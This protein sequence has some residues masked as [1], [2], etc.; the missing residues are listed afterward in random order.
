MRG[1]LQLKTLKL[2][3]GATGATASVGGQTVPVTFTGGAITFTS[4]LTIPQGSTLT[5]TLTSAHSTFEVQP[6][7]LAAI[8]QRRQCNGS[9]GCCPDKAALEKQAEAYSAPSTGIVDL[10]EVI[11]YPI[12][13]I[14]LA[15]FMLVGLGMGFG[16]YLRDGF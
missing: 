5:V 12:W 3:F 2:A 9:A 8:R 13:L 10:H 7:P 11:P 14:I 15:A 6:A 16:Y 4:L 1:S